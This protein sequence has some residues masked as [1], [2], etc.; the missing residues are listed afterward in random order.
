MCKN[1]GLLLVV[2]Q[3]LHMNSDLLLVRALHKS[4]GLLVVV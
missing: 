2:V 1:F 3:A 4:F